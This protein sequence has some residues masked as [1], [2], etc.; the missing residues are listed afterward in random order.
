MENTILRHSDPVCIGDILSAPDFKIV[1][2][3][4]R[5]LSKCK[6]LSL[7]CEAV[8]SEAILAYTR[9]VRLEGKTLYVEFHSAAARSEMLM[10]VS[11]IMHRINAL[12]GEAVV[13][14]IVA[15]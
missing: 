15:R 14:K 6:V 7:W 12:A 4:G 3:A 2:A 13:T 11:D 10:Q 5:T 1:G 8:D 9:S